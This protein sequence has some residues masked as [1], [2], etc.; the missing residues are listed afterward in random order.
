MWQQSPF[1][2]FDELDVE[3]LREDSDDQLARTLASRW[4]LAMR[5][6]SLANA[7]GGT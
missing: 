5:T 2:A 6:A 7:S 4:N 3:A 1:I